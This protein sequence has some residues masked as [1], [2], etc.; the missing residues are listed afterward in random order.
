[1]YTEHGT[2]CR[3]ASMKIKVSTDPTCRD[4]LESEWTEW[5]S[6]VVWKRETGFRE[7][8]GPVTYGSTLKVLT[9]VYVPVGS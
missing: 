6:L 2:V 7:Y 1:M 8:S 4:T 3:T 9:V 5:Y